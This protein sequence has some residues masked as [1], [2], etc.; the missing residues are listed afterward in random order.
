MTFIGADGKQRIA[1]YS[2]PG[3]W[4]GGVV[5]GRLSTDDPFAGLGAVGAMADL[6]MFTPAGGS[7]HVFKLR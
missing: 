2:G 1:V 4:A 6:P 3:G 7:V 5:P